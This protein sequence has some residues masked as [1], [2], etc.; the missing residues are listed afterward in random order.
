MQHS[1]GCSH[2]T[3]LPF[4]QLLLNSALMCNHT[5]Q[6]VT[7]HVSVLLWNKVRVYLLPMQ[8]MDVL[9]TLPAHQDGI[10]DRAFPTTPECDMQCREEMCPNLCNAFEAEIPVSPGQGGEVQTAPR[11]PV[12]MYICRLPK[13]VSREHWLNLSTLKF[14]LMYTYHSIQDCSE[15]WPWTQINF[16]LCRCAWRCQQSL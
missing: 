4:I 13:A 11:L 3:N 9:P 12:C 8:F 15:L 1:L 16:D 10:C 2:N 7:N 14:C 6:F 5:V